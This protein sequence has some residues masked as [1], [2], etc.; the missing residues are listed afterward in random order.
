MVELSNILIEDISLYNSNF[1]NVYYYNEIIVRQDSFRNPA[2]IFIM[3][4]GDKA[5]DISDILTGAWSIGT[6]Y[7]PIF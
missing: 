4:G 2:I 1:L 6:A 5:K 7:A 3:N